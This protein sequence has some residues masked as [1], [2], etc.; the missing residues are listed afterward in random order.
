MFSK[1]SVFCGVLLVVLSSTQ[2]FGQT[3]TG[4]ITGTVTDSSGAVIPNA[5]LTITNPATAA[6]RTV[7]ASDQGLYSVPALTAGTYQVRVEVSGFQTVQRDAQVNAGSDTTV[8]IQMTVGQNTQVVEVEAATA[9]MN[10]D[11]AAFAG[12]VERQSIQDLPLNGRFFMQLATLEPGVT[13]T[14]GATSAR[15]TQV[16]LTMLGGASGAQGMFTLDGLSIM[17][18]Y[19]GT[20]T[21]INFSQEMVQEFQIATLN[22]D[23]S[24]SFTGVGSVNIVSRGGSNDFHGSAFYFYR[25]HNMA[26]YPAL[27]RSSF[28]PNPF[29]QRKNP[30]GWVSGPIIK[31]KLFF[32]FDYEITDQ[33]QALSA[34]QDLAALQPLNAVYSSPQTYHS[35]NVRL[36]YRLSD[37]TTLWARYT[38]DGNVSFG[39]NPSGG[40]GVGLSN[41][42]NNNNWSDQYALGVTTA[43]SPT[44]V[45]DFRAGLR[46]WVS[47]ETLPT[48]AQCPAPCLGLGSF[49][50]IML[51]SATFDVGNNSLGANERFLHGLHVVDSVSWQKGA[52]QLRF[53]AE[54]DYQWFMFN[55]PYNNPGAEEVVA[56]SVAAAT[57][58][59]PAAALAAIP[60]TITSNQDLLNLPIYTL[61]PATFQGIGVGPGYTPGAYNFDQDSRDFKP[62]FFASDSWKIRPNL[63]LNFGLG[64]QF[65]TGEFN[66]D[67]SKPAFL[68]PLAGAFGGLSPTKN[69][70]DMF[71][72]SFGFSWSPGKSGKWVIRGGAGSYYDTTSAY[73]KEVENSLIGPVGN[74]RFSVTSGVF[75]NIFPGIQQQGPNGTFV[76]LAVGAP[77]P[78][79]VITT[80]TLGQFEQIYNQQFPA[81]SALL[82]PPVPKSGPFTLTALD[83]VK[84]GTRL[85]PHSFPMVHSYQTSLGIQRDLGHNMVLTVDWARR[86]FEHTLL[87]APATGGIDLNHFNEFVNGVQSP[88]I[89]VCNGSQLFVTS[90]ECSTGAISILDPQGRTLYEAMLVKLSKRFSNHFQF[91]ASYALQNDNSDATVYNLNNFMQSYGPVLARHNLNV[92]GLVQLKYGFELSLNSSIIS[93][94]PFNPVVAGVDLT[95]TGASASGYLNGINGITFN[96]F[97]Q[98]C[99]KNQLAGAVAQWNSTLAGTKAQNGATI[100]TLTLPANYDFGTSSI[101]QDVR[102]TKTFNFKERY[103]FLVMADVFNAINHANLTG[104]S[105]V[106]GSSFGQPTARAAQTFLSGGPRAIQLGA[107]F[108]F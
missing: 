36:D 107:R 26:A 47:K 90:A 52:H 38:H 16:G 66:S 41:W 71:E 104:Y 31:D 101:T 79:S 99:G 45:N 95:G 27:K 92:S 54:N 13:V 103:R 58:G 32:F 49:Q 65:Q 29:F 57:K 74:S 68:Q 96:C 8:N 105:T 53:G 4:T 61:Q 85:L 5:T 43:F 86:Q 102:V 10:Y 12:S 9:Q 15:N 88:V 46:G 82:S 81:L 14:A 22:Y 6:T 80:M 60:T 70:Y 17:D 108:Q 89:P 1:T 37:K 20:G 35:L 67:L 3:A 21:V 93:K 11:N 73:T 77:I 78:T 28:L 100:P 63:T 87:S 56:P 72:P 51:G 50:T 97:N 84:A 7:T 24:N 98:G 39:E 106:I 48:S 59:F 34:Q 55:W 23:I 75:T 83:Y 42:E 40:S 30:G 91:L 44:V 69:Q 94:T 19:D 33:V 18:M 2:L 64:Y 62:H 25:D 76:P